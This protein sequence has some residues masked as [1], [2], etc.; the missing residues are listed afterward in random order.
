MKRSVKPFGLPVT[1]GPCAIIPLRSDLLAYSARSGSSPGVKPSPRQRLVEQMALES[2]FWSMLALV[3]YSYCLYPLIVLTI[4]KLGRP[5]GP[6][7]EQAGYLPA[8]SVVI[9]VFNEENVL[10]AKLKNL[11]SLDYPK[12]KI[13]FLFGSDGSNDRT[14]DILSLGSKSIITL[15]VFTERR[16]KAT[17][18]ND[19]LSI[20]KGDIIVFSDANTIYARDTIRQLTKHFQLPE[21]GAVCGELV[22]EHDGNSVGSFGESSYWKYENFLKNI[23]SRCRT[24]LGA[25]GGIYAIRKSLYRPLPTTKAITDDFLIP[26]NVLSQGSCVKYAR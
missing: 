7:I 26:L 25:T 23:E 4:V 17:V 19:L 5:G 9:S 24:I 3:V 6:P 18:L 2:L 20:A 13:E 10:E 22:L 11:A 21:V 12:D 16:G 14:N 8:V 1:S 15:K